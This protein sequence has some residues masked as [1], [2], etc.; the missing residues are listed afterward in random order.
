VPSGRCRARP[1]PVPDRV[2]M[3]SPVA[4][5]SAARLPRSLS[6]DFPARR[7]CSGA[8]WRV[9]RRRRRL[10]GS[11]GAKLRCAVSAGVG[12]YLTCGCRR[13][14]RADE[15]G[16]GAAP[17]AARVGVAAAA[18]V[19]RASAAA[20]RFSSFAPGDRGS[21][22]A[23][24]TLDPVERG[25]PSPA[26]TWP[27]LRAR[28]ARHRDLRRRSAPAVATAPSPRLTRS[29]CSSTCRP[30]RWT[31]CSSRPLAS[32]SRGALVVYSHVR[33]NAPIAKGLRATNALAR[34]LERRP[35]RHDAGAPASRITSNP[36]QDAHH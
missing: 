16:R 23:A 4:R 28:S 3:I 13:R 34:G 30:R 21:P 6:P 32:S 24:R 33:K 12:D 10:R 5:P 26:S 11:R 7:S 17:V 9:P 36:L 31:R 27:V 15:D 35:D 20:A 22:A 18:A 1:R 8:L 29:T 19:G 14:R 25:E 2:R